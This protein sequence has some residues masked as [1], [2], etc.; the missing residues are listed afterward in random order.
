MREGAAGTPMEKSL[1][2]GETPRQNVSPT[3]LL[4][5]VGGMA[6]FWACFFAMLMRNSFLDPG[7]DR[8]WYHLALRIVF[9][10]GFGAC[11]FA[12]SHAADGLPAPRGRRAMYALVVLFCVIAAVSPTV[13]AALGAPLPLAFD[14]VAWALSGAG[15]GCLLF[16]WM[17]V[18]SRMDERSVARCMALSTA[19]GGFLYLVINLLPSYFSI[20]M[21]V[22]CP[23]VSL[24]V[25]RVVAHE[26][27]PADEER[28]PLATSRENAGMSWAFGVIYVVYGIVFGL[29]AGSVTQLPGD[30]LLFGGIA[31][32]ILAGAF[33]ALAFMKRFAGRMRQID[34][35]RMVFPFLVVSLVAMALFTGPVYALSNLLLLAA[36]VFLVVT[37][38]AFEVHTA[39]KRHAAPLFFVG[40]SQGVLGAGMAAGFALGLLPAVAGAANYSVLSGVALGLVVV[41]AAF[42][43]FAPQHRPA[44][45]EDAATSATSEQE[46]EQGRWKARCAVVARDAKLSA[47]ET[48]V[49]YLMAKGRGIEHIQNKLCISSHTVKSH[50]YNI[51]RKMGI[52]SREELLDAIEAAD[53]DE[54]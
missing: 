13:Y 27:E 49:F 33:A 46:H 50:T 17:P 53:P 24:G 30:P 23:L 4:S 41:L 20:V 48:E 44:D 2:D 9:F 21:L 3:L 36:Y 35:L 7:I 51:Y 1:S 52:N 14:L 47:R 8:L 5:V 16:V 45:D 10:V 40:M 37:S 26:A 29:G 25:E 18:V 19:C 43:T 34:M 12:L 32:F 31:A 11:A 28:V 39:H 15:L 6:L 54:A 42:I 22:V 38:M